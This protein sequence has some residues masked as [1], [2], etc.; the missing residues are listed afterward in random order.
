MGLGEEESERAREIK[1]RNSQVNGFERDGGRVRRMAFLKPPSTLIVLNAIRACARTFTSNLAFI[2]S[3]STTVR[4]VVLPSFFFVLCLYFIS[5][6]V[7]IIMACVV[8]H[9]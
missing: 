1:F 2:H 9:L 6:C 7:F 8:L 3:S 5:L 4:V